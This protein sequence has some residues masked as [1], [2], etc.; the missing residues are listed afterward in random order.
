MADL[1]KE[2]GLHQQERKRMANERT[3]LERER[4]VLKVEVNRGGYKQLRPV[5]LIPTFLPLPAH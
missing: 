1:E 2:I 3:A 5:S 4:E